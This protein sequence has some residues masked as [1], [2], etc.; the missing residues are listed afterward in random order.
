MEY[1][2]FINEDQIVLSKTIKDIRNM[3]DLSFYSN[4]DGSEA[5]VNNWNTFIEMISCGIC[6]TVLTLDKNPRQCSN[7]KNTMFCITCTA[8]VGDKCCFCN[9][10]NISWLPISN[11]LQTLI[12][13]LNFKCMNADK[14]C[15]EILKGQNYEIEKH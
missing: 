12:E 5:Q 13:N 8:K 11:T 3:L 1:N 4:R 9:N 10:R 15:P 14:G 7:C 6:Y 2:N